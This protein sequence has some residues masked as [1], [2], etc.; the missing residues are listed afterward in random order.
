MAEKTGIETNADAVARVIDEWQGDINR[1]MAR[2]APGV[3]A[4]LAARSV[5]DYMQDA[6]VGAG[7][8]SPHDQ[9]P[10]RKVTLRLSRSLQNVPGAFGTE[11]IQDVEIQGGQ[12]VVRWGSRVPY[13]AV[14][15]M[16][17]Q[18]AVNVPPHTRNGGIKVRGHVRQMDIPARPYMMPAV[19]DELPWIENYVTDGVLADLDRRLAEI[20]A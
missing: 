7:R 2:L 4:R 12:L 6:G 13:A 18:G 20:N 11:G 1:T 5:T 19:T 3:F 15:E 8:R 16:G 17:F 14:H 9:G 10:L